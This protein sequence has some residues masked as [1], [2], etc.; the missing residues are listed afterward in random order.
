VHASA[1]RVSTLATTITLEHERCCSALPFSSLRPCPRGRGDKQ[2]V[3][4]DFHGKL[5]LLRGRC[6]KR[7][8]EWPRRRRQAALRK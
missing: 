5:V 2:S 4:R 7:H 3:A 1:I 6:G 8:Q